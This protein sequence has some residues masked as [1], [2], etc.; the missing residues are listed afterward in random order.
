MGIYIN[1]YLYTLNSRD[2][3]N[4]VRLQRPCKYTSVLPKRIRSMEE[5][6]DGVYF[7]L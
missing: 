7:F 4:V 2:V 1:I 3:L 5:H 6:V